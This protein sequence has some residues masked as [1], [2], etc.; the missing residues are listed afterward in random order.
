MKYLALPGLALAAVA[1]AMPAPVGRW[2]DH[3]V[4]TP[5]EQTR[6]PGT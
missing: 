3:K 1:F 5:D 4:E 6:N 2:M